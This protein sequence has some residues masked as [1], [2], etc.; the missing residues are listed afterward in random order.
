MILCL[1]RLGY[2]GQFLRRLGEKHDDGEATFYKT[3]CFDLESYKEIFFRQIAEKVWF[4]KLVSIDMY[5]NYLSVFWVVANG[6][7]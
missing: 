6:P 3:S 5:E 7:G 4:S 1:C 2:K